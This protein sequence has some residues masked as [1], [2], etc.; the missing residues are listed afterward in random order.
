MRQDDA[1]Q[2]APILGSPTR[3]GGA[4]DPSLSAKSSG[5]R[6]NTGSQSFDPRDGTETPHADMVL[7]TAQHLSRMMQGFV[8]GLDHLPA[9]LVEGKPATKKK[10]AGYWYVTYSVRQAHD[11]RMRRFIVKVNR[12]KSIPERRRQGRRLAAEINARLALGWNP[13]TEAA[14]PRAH[15]KLVEAMDAFLEAKAREKLEANSL[16]SYR[17]SIGILKEWLAGVRMID[18]PVVAFQTMHAREFML[19]SYTKRELS[20]RGWNN[21]HTFYTTLWRWFNEMGYAEKNV[22][23]PIKKKRVDPDD[24]SRRP[25]NEEE[26]IMIRKH[27]EHYDPRFLAF[28]LLTFH[29][30]LRPKETFLLKPEHFHLNEMY[31]DIPKSISKVKRPRHA[32]IAR[33]DMPIMRALKVHEQDP[34]EYVFSTGF[35]PGRKLKDSRYVGTHWQR[36]RRDTGLSKDVS[37]YTLK[38]AGGQQLFSDGIDP[39]ELMNHFG[40]RDLKMT[41]I[42][43]RA[44]LPQGSRFVKNRA[45]EF[46]K[47]A[48]S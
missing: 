41:T 15:H 21:Y 45:S 31:V 9:R 44:R 10:K 23:E 42:Y 14:T 22:F 8:S 25:P 40:H 30:G 7:V 43:T 13:L 19:E 35:K 32:A 17:S 4:T 3:K 39:N 6:V 20:S 38:H 46:G 47:P 18:R 11:G 16:R 34:Q 1:L 27:V 2:A 5:S 26:Q 24:T 28:C 36:L 12:V 29:S 33:V 48:K 37:F